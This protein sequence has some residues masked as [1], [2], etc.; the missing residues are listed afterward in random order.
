VSA[1]FQRAKLRNLTIAALATLLIALLPWGLRPAIA[2]P[3]LTVL[4]GTPINLASGNQSRVLFRLTNDTANSLTYAISVANQPVGLVVNFPDGQSQAVPGNNGTRDFSIDFTMPPYSG[5]FTVNV[6]ASAGGSTL[7]APVRFIV[8]GPTITPT[9]SGAGPISLTP[10]L[11][12]VTGQAG[13]S[14]ILVNVNLTNNS[15]S[16]RVFALSATSLPSGVSIRFPINQVTVNSGSSFQF[17]VFVDYAADAPIG[18][19]IGVGRIQANSVGAGTAL[20]AEAFLSFTINVAQT[21]T[22]SPTSPACE[23]GREINDPGNDKGGARLILVNA[24]EEHGICSTGDEDWFKFG[25]VGGKVYTIDIVR[26]DF[27]LDLSLELYDENERLLATNDDFFART[28]PPANA[29]ATPGPSG[30]I[31][32]RIQSWTA[33]VDGLY[34][35]RVRDTLNIGGRDAAYT[36]VVVAESFGPTP[37]LVYEICRDLFEEDGLPEE[38][39]LITSNE[40]QPNK[41]LCPTGDADWVRFFGKAGKTYYLYTDTRPY[42]NQGGTT[43][44]GGDTTLALVDRDGTTLLDFNDDIQSPSDPASN[45]LDSEIRFTPSVDG[46]YFAQV[47]NSGDIGNQFIRYNLTLRLCVPGQ[48]CGRAPFTAPAPQQPSGPQATPI[49]SPQ[50]VPTRPLATLEPTVTPTATPE[51]DTFNTFQ[52]SAAPPSQMVNG[53]VDGFVDAAFQAVW[54]RNDRPVAEQRVTRSWM[55]GPRGLMA[56]VEAYSQVPGGM[57]Q[58]QYFDKGRMEVN[59]PG[60]DRS[61]R[62]FVTSGLLVVELVTGKMQVGDSEFVQRNPAD[63]PVAGDPDDPDTPRYYSFGGV[64]GQL[65]GDRT[66][67]PVTETLDRN[68][69]IGPYTGPARAETQLARYVPE[70]QHNIPRVFWELLNSRGTIYAAGYRS[71]LLVD[72]VFA[73]GYP[74]SEPYWTRVRIGGVQRDVLVQVFERR[75]LTY[76]PENPPGWRVEQGNVGRHY[77]LWRYGEPLP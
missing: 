11:Q 24:V 52:Q 59:N 68:G 50:V 2:S 35:I 21:V 57:R 39:K 26:M 60:G 43:V 54:E 38:A 36:I 77:H 44:A 67:Q 7:S 76:T 4:T 64:T 65:F 13:Q 8:T 70:S 34:Y 46:F 3:T 18:T 40:T 17:P 16:A 45:S 63:M 72:W 61:N 28:P 42:A 31:R 51:S 14:G 6:Q 32:P 15:G 33:P 66:G 22:P 48:E 75:V 37:A 47:K 23:R 55:W 9:V 62:W 73:M 58:V 74:I 49:S 41:V 71:D 12:N 5:D 30:D 10:T 19:N 1:R 25:A 29:T 53:P 69:Q 56:R 27:G 20:S